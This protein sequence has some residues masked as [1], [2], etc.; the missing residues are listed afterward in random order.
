MAVATP[1]IASAVG[2]IVDTV[3]RNS[4]HTGVL[5]DIN[6]KLDSKEFYSALIKGLDIYFNNKQ[7]YE[8]MVS[9]CLSEDFSW[10][11]KGKIGPVYD[12]LELFGIS[13]ESLPDV[14]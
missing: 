9:D 12:Y 11:Q 14:V 3:N 1:V 10:I 5:T 6:K 4:K 7:E 13:R 8:N 2:G